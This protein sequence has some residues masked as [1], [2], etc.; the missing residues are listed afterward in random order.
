MPSP[1]PL[2]ER[3]ARRVGT[4]AEARRWLALPRLSA[5]DWAHLAFSAKESFYKCW[6]P[7]TR[8]PLGFA[9]AEIDFEPDAGRFAVRLL[10]DDLPAATP[11]AVA[12]RGR[13]EAGSKHLLTAVYLAAEGSDPEAGAPEGSAR[14]IEA[15]R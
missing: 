13:F 9:D 4:R 5:G 2:T 14:T 3:L 12:F 1:R 6:F 8:I 7:L 10:R 15:A 11:A